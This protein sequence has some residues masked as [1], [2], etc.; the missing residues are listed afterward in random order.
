MLLCE[1]QLISLFKGEVCF[2]GDVER[3]EYSEVGES[4]D[5]SQL[6]GADPLQNSGIFVNNLSL[7]EV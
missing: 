2:E 1:E 3:Q 5:V 4:S 6:E 7:L